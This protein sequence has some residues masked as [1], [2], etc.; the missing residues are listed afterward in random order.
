MFVDYV[1]GCERLTECVFVC[2]LC[3]GK[4]EIDRVGLSVCV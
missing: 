4:G 2:R 3:E 1:K